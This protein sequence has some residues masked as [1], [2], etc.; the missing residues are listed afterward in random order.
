MTKQE[1]SPLISRK[2]YEIIIFEKSEEISVFLYS[3]V[4]FLGTAM[5]SEKC[6]LLI[7]DEKIDFFSY[8]E[9]CAIFVSI[10]K[11][12]DIESE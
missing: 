1:F 3:R 11:T 6:Y 4:N 2:T 7:L 10:S 8:F 12:L 5:A 9:K